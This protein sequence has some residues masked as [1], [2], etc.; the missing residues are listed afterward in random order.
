MLAK[1][2][3]SGLAIV[4]PQPGACDYCDFASMCRIDPLR[5][6]ALDDEEGSD[7]AGFSAESS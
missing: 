4:D 1:E 7:E 6:D 5:L 2:I 3:K